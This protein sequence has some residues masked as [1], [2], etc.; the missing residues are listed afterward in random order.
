MGGW[1]SFNVSKFRS[2]AYGLVLLENPPKINRGP[3]DPIDKEWVNRVLCA[4]FERRGAAVVAS[5]R[6]ILTS[7]EHEFKEL[8]LE[9]ELELDG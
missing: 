3:S 7:R 8:E 4:E 2:L 5:Q 6:D 1:W 9:L